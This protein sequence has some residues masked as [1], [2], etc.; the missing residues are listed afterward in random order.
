MTPPDP[1]PATLKEMSRTV[2]ETILAPTMRIMEPRWRARAPDLVEAN[3][4]NLVNA[5]TLIIAQAIRDYHDPRVDALVEAGRD[6]ISTIE[7][8]GESWPE[9]VG[10]LRVALAP[11]GT[12]EPSPGDPT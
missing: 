7:S 10:K 1:V 12:P 11:Y 5:A 2:A 4:R 6:A 8:G 9:T 3:K